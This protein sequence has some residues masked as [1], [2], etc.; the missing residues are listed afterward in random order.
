M[1]IKVVVLIKLAYMKSK[2]T[3]MARLFAAM[4]I[5]C[6]VASCINFHPGKGGKDATEE[7]TEAAE[8]N[9]QDD[10]EMAQS[11]HLKFKGV[12]IDGSLDKFV[13][14]MKRSNFK[15]VGTKDGK[16]VLTGDFADF[17]ECTINV[18][19]L[20]GK[21]LVSSISV[22]FPKE[23]QWEYLYGDYKHLKEML[24]EKYGKPSSCVEKFQGSHGLKPTDDNDKIYY[25]KFDRCKYESRFQ[26][27]N[28]EI[29]LRIEHRG[30]VDCYVMLSYKD[31]ENGSAIR[32]HAK[33]DL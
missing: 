9:P 27:S 8:S 30:P 21:D 26:A 11:T 28:G 10:A 20:E 25:V 6:F 31:K 4:F 3:R 19:T 2:T 24:T 1:K 5:C 15:L 18:A 7:N 16:A 12:P 29:V 23:E 17:K 32:K 14:R 33:E 13:E 22:A